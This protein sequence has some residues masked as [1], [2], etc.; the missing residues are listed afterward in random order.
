M[1]DDQKTG[2]G[3]V[4]V[5]L[6]IVAIA[7]PKYF[8]GLLGVATLVLAPF[9]IYK[10]SIFFY[11]MSKESKEVEREQNEIREKVER[12]QRQEYASE[13][14]TKTV[15]AIEQCKSKWINIDKIVV[16]PKYESIDL[17]EKIWKQINDIS[18]DICEIGVEN[19]LI[20]YKNKL[21]ELKIAAQE[22]IARLE[23]KE[24]EIYE[25]VIDCAV[26]AGEHK[27]AKEN[28]LSEARKISNNQ[29]HE[30]SKEE[31][32]I[33]E[34]KLD[35]IKEEIDIEYKELRVAFSSNPKFT[36][37][38]G[39]VSEQQSIVKDIGMSII[40]MQNFGQSIVKGR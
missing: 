13:L 9:A 1:T 24:K 14:K 37:Y 15:N 28:L 11:N 29:K 10:M 23:A 17:Q 38:S 19:K 4:S 31:K 5:I 36:E 8:F 7:E 20:E 25:Q 18:L 27:F 34:R 21:N 30:I 12:E 26:V 40:Q 22:N 3:C 6:I 16:N 33:E 2:V 39:L 32:E 35:I